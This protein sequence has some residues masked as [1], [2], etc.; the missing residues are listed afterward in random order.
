[1]EWADVEIFV[2]LRR[3]LTPRNIFG[4]GN[5]FGYSTLVLST[6]FCKTSPLKKKPNKF[7]IISF[8]ASFGSPNSASG[9]AAPC[10]A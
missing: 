6:I 2:Q 1:M 5:A 3:F 7:S 4:V 9:L 8:I 10:S